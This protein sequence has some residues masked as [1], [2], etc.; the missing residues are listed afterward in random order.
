MNK[1]LHIQ[2]D[3]ALIPVKLPTDVSKGQK[4]SEVLA[5]GEHSG[6]GHVAENVEVLIG[7]DD[8]RYLVPQKDA[9]VLHK[10]LLT[11]HGA[12]HRELLLPALEDGWA[13]RVV[14]QSEYNPEEGIFKQVID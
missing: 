7:A 2:G 9:R 12:D 13:Y 5:L 10:H 6:H 14:I 1:K 3:V 4:G 11:G 8:A